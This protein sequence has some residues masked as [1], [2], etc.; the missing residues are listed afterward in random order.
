LDG[1]CVFDGQQQFEF[2][3]IASTY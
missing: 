2:E 1:L 3:D